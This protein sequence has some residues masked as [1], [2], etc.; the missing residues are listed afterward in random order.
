MFSFVCDQDF[1][2]ETL[3]NNKIKIKLNFFNLI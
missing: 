3:E 2:K 1:K